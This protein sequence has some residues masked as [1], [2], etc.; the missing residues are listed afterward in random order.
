MGPKVT[1]IILLLLSA[2]R[3]LRSKASVL[4]LKIHACGGTLTTRLHVTD[5]DNI[6][7]RHCKARTRTARIVSS[8]N[9]GPVKPDL[10]FD[11][12]SCRRESRV[13]SS[14]LLRQRALV[15]VQATVPSS[16][17][18]TLYNLQ[19]PSRGPWQGGFYGS[20]RTLSHQSFEILAMLSG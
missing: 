1:A 17:D 2:T 9:S 18:V 15:A 7:H 12:R 5:E 10:T 13:S 4:V 8:D 6:C 3:L 14:A 19:S 11:R 20:G 16:F